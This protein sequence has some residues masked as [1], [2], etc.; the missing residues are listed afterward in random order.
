MGQMM[1]DRKEEEKKRSTVCRGGVCISFVAGVGIIS[2]L[3]FKAF[4]D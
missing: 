4:R 2:P 3:R 1:K